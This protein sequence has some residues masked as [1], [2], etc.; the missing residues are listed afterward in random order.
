[1][2]PKMIVKLAV[3]AAMTIA[4]LLLMTYELI[5]QA[6]H[7][8][9]GVV[10][11]VLFIVHH[12]L[13]SHWGRNLR[14]GSYHAVRIV[15]TVLV[16]LVLF[17]MVGSMASGVILSR[18]IFSFLSIRGFRSFARNLHMLSAYWGFMFMAL[19]LGFH[20]DMMIGVAGKSVKKRSKSRVWTIRALAAVIAGYGVYALV[21]REIVSYMLLKNQFVFFDFDEPLLFFILDYVAVMWLFAFIGYVLKGR[22]RFRKG[23][24]ET[25]PKENG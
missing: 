19:H 9:I 22:I 16:I 3:D 7:E 24:R 20:L 12:V 1:M 11:F 13:N 2:K 6:A 21:D 14:K 4:L 25:H 18:H 17:S 23:K 8:W 15:Q 5:G 10:M